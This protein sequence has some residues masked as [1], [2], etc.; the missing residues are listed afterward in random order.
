M[1][2]ADLRDKAEKRSRR[3][4]WE[5]VAVLSGKIEGLG[6]AQ[7]TMDKVKGEIGCAFEGLGV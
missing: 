4:F 1:A 6:F 2:I 5:K 3:G 7:G